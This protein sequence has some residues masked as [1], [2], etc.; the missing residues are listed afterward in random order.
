MTIGGGIA[1]L[2]RL[3]RPRMRE[4]W[5]SETVEVG[6]DALGGMIGIRLR[7]RST[8]KNERRSPGER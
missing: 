3:P 1:R 2:K 8:S 6:G 7:R 4:S 5:F